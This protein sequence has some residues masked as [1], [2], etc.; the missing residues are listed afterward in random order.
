MLM[1]ESCHDHHECMVKG[2]DSRPAVQLLC[3]LLHVLIHLAVQRHSINLCLHVRQHIKV[4][5]EL[6]S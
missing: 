3:H 4:A 6:D 2:Q 5:T 1:A